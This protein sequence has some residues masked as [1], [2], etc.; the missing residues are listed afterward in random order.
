MKG[1]DKYLNNS[2]F[3]IPGKSILNLCNC[4]KQEFSI[5]GIVHG[6]LLSNFQREKF[7]ELC[8]NLDLKLLSPLWN[9]PQYEYMKDLIN[10]NFHFILI[11]VS[12]DGLD[13]SWLGKEITMTELE[14]LEKLSTKFGFNLSFE[15]G[16]A[17][18]LV[19]DCPLFSYPIKIKKFNK[20]WDGYRGRFEIED[21]E[22][23]YNVR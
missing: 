22:L 13:D 10:S 23:D 20:I 4:A 1:L 18:T 15:G 8:K 11:N 12:A 21:A 19:I 16:E 6:G 17:E 7:D 14:K 2:E 3:R 5:E 9:I